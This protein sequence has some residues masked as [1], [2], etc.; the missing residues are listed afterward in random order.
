MY[1]EDPEYQALK[2][3]VLSSFPNQKASLKESMKKFWSIK[4]NLSVDDDLIV[5]GCRLYMYIPHSLR[6][7][8]FSRLHEAH[9]GTFRSQA[10]ACPIGRASMETSKIS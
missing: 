10:Q 1:A 6:T 8:M 3:T 7:T 9:Q 4:D 5:Y 2:K